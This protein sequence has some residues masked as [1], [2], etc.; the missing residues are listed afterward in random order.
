M[1]IPA[2]PDDLAVT[3]NEAEKR[4]EV[5]VQG[6]LAV[7]DYQSQGDRM[8]FTHT[9]VPSELRG[10]GIAQKLVRTALDFAKEQNVKVVPACS[11]VS[12]FIQRA[13]EYQPLL[14]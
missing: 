2:A 5:L 4:F 10:R 14:A 7:C 11:Y 1:A 3:H 9:Y 6:Q 8:I 13:R 12:A